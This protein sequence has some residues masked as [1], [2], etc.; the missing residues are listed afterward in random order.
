MDTNIGRTDNQGSTEITRVDNKS[1]T[2]PQAKR[3]EEA[4]MI[5]IVLISAA[6]ITV[7][8]FWFLIGAREF[9]A[10]GSVPL[11]IV[12]VI[13]SVIELAVAAVKNVR[14]ERAQYFVLSAWTAISAAALNIVY[15][16]FRMLGV[17]GAYSVKSENVFVIISAAFFWFA[18]PALFASMWTM[19]T[20]NNET[21]DEQITTNG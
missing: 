1:K 4:R 18:V 10:A 17:V 3:D 14:Q 12:F 13:G 9:L 20:D 11:H 5:K 16:V 8:S 21:D 6:I 2:L 19:T 15:A 7:A